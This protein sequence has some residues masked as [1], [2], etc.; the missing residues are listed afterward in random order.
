MKYSPFILTIVIAIV[1]GCSTQ[2]SAK[3]ESGRRM[4]N[5]G[6]SVWIYVNHVKPDK[7]QQFE[8][9]VTEI[10]WSKGEMLSGKDSEVFHKTRVLYPTQPERD[11]TYSYIFIMDPVI[12]GGDYDI[13]NLLKKIY[14]EAKA[15]EY[16]KMFD[17]TTAAEQTGY[18]VVQSHY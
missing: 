14:G 17:E 11:S 5:E 15:A 7:R 12:T 1:S 13:G 8:K 2:S 18:H 6:D 9:F 4:A 10:F 16:I 3:N